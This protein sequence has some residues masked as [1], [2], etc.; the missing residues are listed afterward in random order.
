MCIT[1]NG[2][3]QRPLGW[4]WMERY[5]ENELESLDVI[6]APEQM[7]ATVK[8]V[9]CKVTTRQRSEQ[10]ADRLDNGSRLYC[11]RASLPSLNTA[12]SQHLTP[13]CTPQHPT[14]HPTQM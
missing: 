6:I 1:R 12:S 7:H 10:P 4:I 5:W 8:I 14:L 3:Y 11:Q 2:A 13:C 9:Q